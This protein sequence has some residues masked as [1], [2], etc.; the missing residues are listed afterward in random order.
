MTTTTAPA[1]D[2]LPAA[3]TWE[4]DAAHTDIEASVRHLMV[5]KVRG[6]FTSF[7]GTVQ[8]AEDITDSTVEVSI[9]ARSIDSSN[10][11]RDEHLRSADFL[12]VENH[13]TITFRSTAVQ[14]VEGDRYQIPGTLTIRG[15]AQPVTL[16]V[17]YFGLQT[18]PWGNT[19]AGFEAT[20]EL[21]RDDFDIN[22][23]QA[24]E[25]GGVL[26]SKAVRVELSVQLAPQA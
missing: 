25:T 13:P 11:D 26:V 9:D 23:N 24:L 21:N 17:S 10:A 12:D 6:R 7:S 5:S 18:D 2:T 15:V 1:R 22:W 14:H 8:V 20:A 19:K 4:I 3:G 16:D